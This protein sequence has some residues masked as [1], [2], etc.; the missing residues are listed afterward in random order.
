[1]DINSNSNNNSG[2]NGQ[3]TNHME[4]NQFDPRIS[5]SMIAMFMSVFSIIFCMSAF[6]SA[7]FAGIAITLAILTASREHR[8]FPAAKRAVVFGIIGLV[9]SYSVMV[10]S[11]HTVLNDPAMRKEMNSMTEE[12]TGE[13]FDDV[14]Q[15]FKDTYGIE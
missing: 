7:I 2:N 3:N 11:V 5:M 4:N 13:S 1:M 8:M 15:E 14:W 10:Y 12:M 6:L 9:A